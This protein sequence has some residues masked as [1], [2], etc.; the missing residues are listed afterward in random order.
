[1]LTNTRLEE[2]FERLIKGETI[3]DKNQ[4]I[5]AIYL[6]IPEPYIEIPGFFYI[7]T[8]EIAMANINLLGIAN[9]LSEVLL[10]LNEEHVPRVLE[11]LYNMIGR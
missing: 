10:I 1:M 9:I 6:L 7:I 8:R 2:I 3:V 5:G 11:L 4:N